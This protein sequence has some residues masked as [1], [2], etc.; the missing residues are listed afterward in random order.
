MG[1]RRRRKRK[2]KRKREVTEGAT[3][4]DAAKKWEKVSLYNGNEVQREEG[5]CIRKM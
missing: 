5:K 2:E 4:M 3:R 1:L